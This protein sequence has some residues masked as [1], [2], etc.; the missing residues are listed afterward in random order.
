MRCTANA[1]SNKLTHWEKML[2][3]KTSAIIVFVSM[4][5]LSAT[6]NLPSSESDYPI[7]QTVWEFHENPLRIANAIDI[8]TKNK[9]FNDGVFL[10][11]NGKTILPMKAN[12]ENIITSKSGI[13][14]VQTYQEGLIAR[15]VITNENSILRWKIEFENT[16]SVELWFEPSLRFPVNI[17]KETK[18]WDGIQ[19]CAAM[20]GFRKTSAVS[21]AFPLTA[22][23]NSQNLLAIGTSPKISSSYLE[24]GIDNKSRLYYAT[25]MVLPPKQKNSFEFIVFASSGNF[26]YLD[27]VHGYYRCFTDNIN[28]AKGVDPRLCSGRYTD[29]LQLG[30]YGGGINN[31]GKVLTAGGGYGGVEW[32]FTM[33]HR[34]GDWLGRKE[35]WDFPLTAGEVKVLEKSKKAGRGDQSSQERYTEDRRLLF[36][37]ADL[38]G[39]IAMTFY[40]V[41]YIEKGLIE[42]YNMQKYVFPSEPGISEYRTAWGVDVGNGGH[43]FTWATPFETILRRDLPELI[44]QNNIW[45]FGYDLFDDGEGMYVYRGETEHYLPGWSYDEEGKFIRRGIAFQHTGDFIHSLKK[46]GKTIGLWG[47]GGANSFMGFSQD[48]YMLEGRFPQYL[49][50]GSREN[51][52]LTQLRLLAGHKPIYI[53]MYSSGL[54]FSAF[55]DWTNMSPEDIRQAFKDFSQDLLA[56]CWQYGTIPNV[57]LAHTY[58]TINRELPIFL[59]VTSRGYEPVPAITGNNRISRVRFGENLGAVIVLSNRQREKIKSSE[60]LDSRYLGS[61]LVL[62]VDFRGNQLDYLTRKGRLSFTAD[63][64]IMEN[65]LINVPLAL[66]TTDDV[67]LN[68]SASRK[69]GLPQIIYS[70]QINTP[71]KFRAKLKF[72]PDHEFELATVILN[73]ETVDIQKLNFQQGVNNLII[74]AKSSIFANSQAEYSAFNWKNCAIVIPHDATPRIQGLAAMLQDFIVGKLK[75]KSEITTH[76]SNKSANIILDCTPSGGARGISIQNN[77]ILIHGTDDFDLQQIAWLWLRKMEYSD[78]RFKSDFIPVWGGGESGKKMIEK[79]QLVNIQKYNEATDKIVPWNGFKPKPASVQVTPIDINS[80]KKIQV[81]RLSVADSQAITSIDHPIWAKAAVVNDLKILSSKTDPTQKTEFKLFASNDSLYV[82]FKCNEGNMDRLKNEQTKRDSGIW[83][84]D[85]VEIRLSPIDKDGPKS[86]YPYYVFLTNPRGTQTDILQIPSGINI[87]NE[88]VFIGANFGGQAK[89]AGATGLAWNGEWSVNTQ[90]SK[91][92]WS[93]VFKIPLKTI[94]GGN[95]QLWRLDLYRGEIPNIEHSSWSSYNHATVD[96]PELFGIMEIK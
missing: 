32:G 14:A 34:Q 69:A 3:L 21:G 70:F 24:R 2:Y 88:E 12:Q 59:E 22:L 37:N 53:H 77:N 57:F 48:A 94:N 13:E 6:F 5:A 25:R 96:Q 75:V 41:D 35:L 54:D 60:S 81:P 83:H 15:H 9:I 84:D 78:Q 36:Q 58:Q 91:N 50:D 42:K 7:T 30:H 61:E 33:Y 68:V 67:K 31:V 40:L 90:I 72:A 23:Y 1:L 85:D 55:I 18:Y 62:A 16:S 87:R 49:I 51:T 63:Y 20:D 46:D 38:R 66:E 79:A 95:K 26:G 73:G 86:S 93:G 17:N 65:K 43:V 39:N 19:V 10:I 27:A 82:A 29:T 56:S 4:N 28:P 47:N 64:E 71:D 76:S 11:R 80:L 92:Y 89:D 45:A 52:F 44:N 8:K 74:T